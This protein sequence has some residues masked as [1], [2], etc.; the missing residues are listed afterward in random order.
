MEIIKR[1]NQSFPILRRLEELFLLRL[2]KNGVSFD[3]VLLI[4]CS[5][6]SLKPQLVM[7]KK[8]IALSMG[9]QRI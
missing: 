9:D 8:I 5:A 4:A 1:L 6:D 7:F 3:N 2:E